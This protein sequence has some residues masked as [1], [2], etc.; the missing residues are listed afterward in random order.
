MSVY[1]EYFCGNKISDYGLENGFVDYGTF[2]KAF[3]AVLNNEIMSKTY[4]NGYWEQVGGFV[5]NSAEIEELED[6]YSELEDKQAETEDDNEYDRLSDEMQEISDQ[7]SELEDEQNDM[8]EVFQWY[9][10]SDNAV[11]ILEMN[12]EIVFYNEDLDMYLWGV[13]HYGTA[14]S[15]VLTNIRCNTGEI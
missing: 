14:W 6:K 11:N 7:I 8:P 15:H 10:V 2:S 12:N 1:G 13:T 3:D 4:D 9:I 5:D